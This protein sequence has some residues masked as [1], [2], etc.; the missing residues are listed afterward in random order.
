[1]FVRFATVCTAIGCVDKTI[2]H[3]SRFEGTM[4]ESGGF[5]QRHCNWRPGERRPTAMLRR[6]LEIGR[7]LPHALLLSETAEYR[8]EVHR[9][10]LGGPFPHPRIIVMEP[11]ALP[12]LASLR[13]EF[14][15]YFS[16]LCSL[17]GEVD[18][19]FSHQWLGSVLILCQRG[20]PA[21]EDACA[22]RHTRLQVY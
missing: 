4:S 19:C 22:L 12:H 20:R 15:R 2:G 16:P 8:R 11:A 17:L 3:L 9:V 21:G 6:L 13:C 14:V 7:Q 1:M 10:L 5:N 18:R